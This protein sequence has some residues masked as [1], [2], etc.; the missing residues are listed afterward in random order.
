MPSFVASAPGK[1]IL[2]GEHAVV[3]QQPA[4]AVPVTQFRTRATIIPDVIG[5]PGK[6]RILSPAVNLDC[7]LDSLN[8][9]HPLAAVIDEVITTLGVTHIPACTLKL[10][11]TIPVAAGL[12]SGA[13]VSVA[14]IRVLSA[15]LGMPLEDKSVNKLAFKVEK[16]H[17]GKPSGIDNTVITYNKPVYFVHHKPIEI[18]NIKKPFTVII[19]DTGIPSPT[20]Q[21]INQV[22]EA[23]KN[24]VTHFE[25][26]F[27]AVGSLT[28]TAHQAIKNGHPKRLGPLMNENHELLVEMGVSCTELDKLVNIANANGALG[29]KL[30]GGGQGGNMIV[31][32][33]PENAN[34]ISE[35]LLLAGAVGTVIT[36]VGNRDNANI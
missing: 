18:I 20:V 26:L 8:P 34:S 27:N 13:A 2:F 5:P 29:A 16:I 21:A 7:Q 9:D 6:M 14:V 10:S 25:R 19:A 33:E 4:I 3:Y 17:H 1:I 11:S 30:S 23:R 24:N 12:G 35:S 31:L 36:A 15:F 28:R 22:H 32:T